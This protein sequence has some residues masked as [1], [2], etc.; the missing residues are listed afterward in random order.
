MK[1]LIFTGNRAEYGLLFPLISELSKSKSLEC[2]LLVSGAHLD[3]EHGSTISEIIED[4]FIIAGT[5]DLPS[6]KSTNYSA[7][8][9]IGAAVQGIAEQLEIIKPDLFVVYADRYEGFAAVVA[10][11][12]MTIA[13][14]HIEGGD[15][16]EGGALDDSLR[17]AMTKLS[18]I[19]CA[20]NEI[21]MQRIL[22]LGE[23]PWRVHNIGYPAIDMII[24]KNY[25]SE[26]LINSEF[27]FDKRKPIVLFTQH[28]IATEV[29]QAEFQIKHSIDAL[30][31]LAQRGV[32]I[33][34]TFPNN[35][36]GGK[37]IIKALKKI[38]TSGFDFFKIV[39]SLGRKR[40]HGVLG[41][42]ILGYDVVCIGNT[43]SGIKETPAFN[44]P[45]INI[46]ARQDG[47]LRG[48][49]V[50]QVGYSS[51]EILDAFKIC[52]NSPNFKKEVSKSSNPYGSGG[53]GKKFRRI[54]ENLKI[55]KQ[56][57]QK[58]LKLPFEAN[59]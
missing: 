9:T 10:S 41:L 35:D 22:G 4:G 33:I 13:T 45:T 25:F 55:N 18:H 51:K 29:E 38:D 30:C 14:C 16:T 21:S 39:P 57:I 11:T 52:L 24:E 34:C 47:R 49:N 32:Q 20:T 43:S 59:L 1:V 50:I 15:I 3:K 27:D 2:S 7:T 48:G 42:S 8:L 23:E 54:V 46:G 19:H 31:I 56:L 28:S 53:S 26:T 44:C 17:H 37:F 12:Q 5:V 6:D 40:Y 58:K 36:A